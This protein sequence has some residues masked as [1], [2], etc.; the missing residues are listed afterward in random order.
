MV[1]VSLAKHAHQFCLPACLPDLPRDFVSCVYFRLVSTPE[2]TAPALSD[3][4]CSCRLPVGCRSS[5]SKFSFLPQG[6]REPRAPRLQTEPRVVF[7]TPSSLPACALQLARSSGL[8]TRPDQTCSAVSWGR[9]RHTTH[10][11]IPARSRTQPT[12]ITALSRSLPPLFRGQGYILSSLNPRNPLVLC[13]SLEAR[14]RAWDTL[15]LPLHTTG[16][17]ATAKLLLQANHPQCLP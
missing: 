1:S 13:S 14:L 10:F 16:W 4:S 6:F 7:G 12:K 11:E 15:T 5:T 3:A 17:A 2:Q 8:T 9:P